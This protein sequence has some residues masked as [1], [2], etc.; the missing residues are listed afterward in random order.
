MCIYMECE[1]M[2]IDK[3][4]GVRILTRTNNLKSNMLRGFILVSIPYTSPLILVRIH[5]SISHRH[6][7]QCGKLHLRG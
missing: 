7:E 1:M 2:D 6:G 4:E 3:D 5:H